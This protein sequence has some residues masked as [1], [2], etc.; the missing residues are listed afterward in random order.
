MAPRA[1]ADPPS[2]E[3]EPVVLI[4][5]DDEGLRDSLV[6]LFA[7]VDLKATPFASAKAFLEAELPR[8]PCCLLLDVRMPGLSGLDLQA[9][10]AREDVRIPIV[11]MSAHGDVPMA[12]R[13]LRSGAINFLTKPFRDQELLDAVGPALEMA[14]REKEQTRRRSDIHSRFAEVTPASARF[15]AASWPDGSTSRSPTT[16]GSAR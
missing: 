15:W 14:R 16:S 11:F 6:S 13:A 10:L 12:V 7:S 5:D 8:A 9:E 4:V 2:E 3:D 1:S